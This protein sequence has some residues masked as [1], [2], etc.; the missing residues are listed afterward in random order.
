MVLRG[1]TGFTFSA[2]RMPLQKAGDVASET[3]TR[4]SARSS[5]RYKILK[6]VPEIVL[7]FGN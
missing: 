6:R 7:L 2:G 1:S 4:S 5:S 3:L